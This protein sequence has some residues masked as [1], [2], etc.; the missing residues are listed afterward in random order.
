MFRSTYIWHNWE[1]E[2][3]YRIQYCSGWLISDTIE[4]MNI[5]IEF[6]IVQV[7]L[8]LTQLRIWTWT[9]NLTL[10]PWRMR[11]QVDFVSLSLNFLTKLTTKLLKYDSK[12]D[13]QWII[14]GQEPIYPCT[15]IYLN[16]VVQQLCMQY[17]F[18]K[19][20]WINSN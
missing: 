3:K 8:Y 7:D 12:F 5:N 18:Y 13:F 4:N 17:Y 11:F 10:F 2:H 9:K 19:T 20:L 6:N 1:Y 16:Q 15:C 14:L